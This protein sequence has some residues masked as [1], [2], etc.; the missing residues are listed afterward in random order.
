MVRLFICFF[1]VA[2]T[3]SGQTLMFSEVEK[4]PASVNTNA[5]EIAPLLGADGVTLYFTR[6]LDEANK[7][8]KYAGSDIYSSRYDVTSLNWRKAEDFA[9]LNDKNNNQLI[10]LNLRGDVFYSLNTSTA[11]QPRGI[12][13][14]KRTNGTLSKPELLP[15]EGLK[16]TGFIN[17]F[18]TPEQDVIIASME[19]EDS[20]GEEDLYFSIKKGDSWTS[21]RNMGTTVNTKGFEISPFLSA[22][23][24][25]LYFS[26]NGHPG[27]GG[28]D[29]FYCER[30]YDSWEAWSLPVNLGESI[31]SKGFDAYLS[32]YGDSVAFFASNRSVSTDLYRCKVG[33]KN[34]SPDVILTQDEMK[35]IFGGID[36][37]LVFLNASTS[38]T[39]TH[40]ELLWYIGNKLLDEKGIRLRIVVSPE[41]A[42]ELS[43]ARMDAVISQ[44]ANTGLEG[45]RIQRGVNAEIANTKNAVYLVFTK[46][47][48]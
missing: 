32:I 8:G 24:K 3:A 26:S 18:I 14:T 11:K 1:F 45:S 36:G 13:W 43:E 17:A 2:A 30:L 15:I 9:V 6:L 42:P 12:F 46:I 20:K 34:Q 41:E 5:E 44:L 10:G 40:R 25:R 22:D 35:E 48:Q 4:L 28:G 23:R 47:V 33:L 7:G 29:L 31:N 19:A 27:L 37:R 21:F 16:S 38:L 39:A